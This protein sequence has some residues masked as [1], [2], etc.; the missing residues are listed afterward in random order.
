MEKSNGTL[1]I[2]SEKHDNLTASA[3]DRLSENELNVNDELEFTVMSVSKS[4]QTPT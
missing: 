3:G 4:I 1:T 2:K